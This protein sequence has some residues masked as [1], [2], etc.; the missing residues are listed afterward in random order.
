MYW[1]G[2]GGVICI[3]WARDG[4]Y[5]VGWGWYVLGGGGMYAL[6]SSVVKVPDDAGF[7]VSLANMRRDCSDLIGV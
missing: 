3:R 2:W 4:I 7:T 1:A 5:W 6:G